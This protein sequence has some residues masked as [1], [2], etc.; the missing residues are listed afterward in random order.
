MLLIH[1]RV[2]NNS[3]NIHVFEHKS[4]SITEKDKKTTFN[5]QKCGES[6][7]LLL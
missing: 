5:I 4:L 1:I 7:N 3:I 2:E 6:V